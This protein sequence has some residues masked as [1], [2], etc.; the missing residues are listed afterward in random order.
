[1]VH[2]WG[3]LT[4]DIITSFPIQP[5]KHFSQPPTNLC[6]FIM[7]KLTGKCA[8]LFLRHQN[9]ARL[10]LQGRGL[11]KGREAPAGYGPHADSAKHWHSVN[12]SLAQLPYGLNPI[13]PTSTL[14]RRQPIS[15]YCWWMTTQTDH[16]AFVQMNNIVSHVPLSSKGHISIMADSMPSTC[17]WSAPSIASVK[18]T[19]TQGLGGIH[20]RANWGAWGSAV[21]L[22]RPYHSGMLPP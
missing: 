11:G 3:F 9:T 15:S 22:S 19:A 8:Q 7:A 5:W 18:I 21:H 17:L 12:E 10:T 13:K 2:P 20:R 1:M 14:W 4:D 6:R 16:M